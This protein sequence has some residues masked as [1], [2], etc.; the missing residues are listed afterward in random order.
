MRKP[1]TTVIAMVMALALI[2]VPAQAASVRNWKPTNGNP[3]VKATFQSLRGGRVYL[4]RAD[5]GTTI[6]IY[7][8]NLSKADRDHIA[9]LQKASGKKPDSN[10][11]VNGK[12]PD[13]NAWYV[14]DGFERFHEMLGE[15][16]IKAGQSHDF[17]ISTKGKDRFF[18]GFIAKESEALEK[19]WGE[20]DPNGPF[21]IGP[22]EMFSHA[23]RQDSMGSSMAIGTD[24]K[25]TNDQLKFTI[26]N[27]SKI[28][29]RIVIHT[30]KGQKQGATFNLLG[31]KISKPETTKP[32]TTEP[33]TTKPKQNV[34]P[35]NNDDSDLSKLRATY[36]NRAQEIHQTFVDAING[37]G[38]LKAALAKK[39]NS[40]S[41]LTV[42]Y[43]RDLNR[44]A[45]KSPKLR[46][47][48]AQEKKRVIAILHD[49]KAH[50]DKGYKPQK[51]DAPRVADNQKKL[52]KGTIKW[53]GHSYKLF[54]ERIA[55]TD[56]KKKCE[57]LGGHLVTIES[58]KENAHISKMGASMTGPGKGGVWI[59][60]SDHEEE[61]QWK[62]VTGE[63]LSFKK[64]TRGRPRKKDTKS[65]YGVMYKQPGNKE[66]LWSDGSIRGGDG[67]G[68]A[69]ICEWDS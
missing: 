1:T 50:R 60:C 61:G 42:T 13:S 23:E 9:N 8:K 69:Y 30:R 45:I 19:A 52:P 37:G 31:G 4:K 12:K 35:G 16:M 44:L 24:F 33:K 57:E 17:V 6:R 14:K 65:S 46:A 2:A 54:Q 20:P 7:L 48:V 49:V 56:A 67:K 5:D 28:D 51:S 43:I 41:D 11:K 36:D 10:Q 22:I 39:S 15:F 62:W 26:K 59:G 68:K 66:G 27:H 25:V 34:G 29:T 47:E 64:W 38:I 40:F 3:P 63:P 18:V 58:A 55:W 32:K 21:I 53:N